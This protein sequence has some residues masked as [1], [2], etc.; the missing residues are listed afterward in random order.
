MPKE[1]VEV[2][3]NSV[4]SR[5]AS[6]VAAAPQRKLLREEDPVAYSKLGFSFPSW[7]KWSILSVIFYVQVSMNV[8]TILHTLQ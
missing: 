6:A 8:C 1:D 4:V 7:K 3:Q 2:H 5:S